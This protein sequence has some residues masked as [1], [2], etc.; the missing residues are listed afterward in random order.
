M[1][2]PRPKSSVSRPGN[3]VSGVSPTETASSL[4]APGNKSKMER[5]AHESEFRMLARIRVIGSVEKV[6]P[7]YKSYVRGRIGDLEVPLFV[8]SGNTFR[9]CINQQMF[10]SL[11]LT[12]GDLQP[13]PERATIG[14]AKR[15]SKLTVK[16]ETKEEIPI[17][18]SPSAPPLMIRLVVLPELEMCVN[19]SGPDLA[20]AGIEIKLSEYLTYRNI[21]V[22]FFKRIDFAEGLK[23]HGAK[24]YT[25]AAV[26]IGPLE[27]VHVNA[28]TADTFVVGKDVYLSSVS[29]F[30]DRYD[31]HPWHN[32]VTTVRAAENGNG[33]TKVGMMNTT[34]IPIKVP[35]GTYYGTVDVL[36]SPDKFDQDPFHLC[37]LE[38]EK[39]DDSRVRTETDPEYRIPPPPSKQNDPMLG[40]DF[41]VPPWMEGPTSLKNWKKRADYLRQLYGVDKNK[42]LKSDT[43][44]VKFLMLLLRNWQTFAWDGRYGNTDLVQH[45]I[46]TPPG[47][48][49]VHI[50]AKY[51]NEFLEQSL[52]EQLKKWLKHGVIQ[53]S[54]S[55]W[56][57]NLLAV[58]KKDNASAVRWC[59]DYRA[60]N[61]ETEIDRFLIGDISDNLSRL[62][63]SRLFSALDNSGAFHI[64]KIAPEDRH[65]TSFATKWN[66]FHFTRLPFGLAG[67]PSSYSR[68]VSQVLR[69]IPPEVAVAYVDD[70]LV[71]S[72]TLDEHI[73]GLSRVLNAYRRAGMKL[74][75]SKCIFLSSKIDYLGHTVSEKGIEP[76]EAYV[77]IVE[78]WPP[79]KTRQDILIAIGKFGYY[80]KFIANFAK[81]AKP[82]TDRLQIVNKEEKKNKEDS[83]ASGQSPRE[84]IQLSKQARKK[85]FEKPITLTPAE[86]KSFND[87]K[88]RLVKYPILGHPRF[89]I[90]EEEPFIL[91]TDW[92]QETGTIAGCLSQKQRQKNGSFREVALGYAA[93]KLGK[94][95]L[96]YSSTK[97]EICA[98]LYFMRYFSYFLTHKKFLIRTDNM[99]ARAIKHADDPPGMIQRWRQRLEAFNFDIVH[100]AGSRH[101]NAD[102]LSR[103]SHVKDNEPAED[104]DVFDE[105]TD[106][107]HLHAI[108]GPDKTDL[109]RQMWT[110]EYIKALQEEDEEIEQVRTW[111]LTKTTPATV[112]R[113]QGS[114]TLK[115]Y[116]NLL[117]SMSIGKDGVLR[118]H[119]VRQAYGDQDEIARWI[120]VLPDHATEQAV[121]AIHKSIAHLRVEN[122]MIAA[123]HY[124][125]NPNL[126]R[127]AEYVCRTC[128]TCQAKG[129]KVKPQSHTLEPP[130]QGYPFFQCNADIVGPL[131]P[132][133]N[134]NV[135]I[136]TVECM[137]TRW[138]E[139]YPLRV[140]T[141][142]SIV[143]KLTKEFFPRFGFPSLLKFDRGTH[144]KNK[145]I[146]ELTEMLGIRI[147]WSPAYHPS[148]NPVERQ[149]RTLKDMLKALIWENT[150]EQPSKWEDFLPAALFALRTMRN[151]ATG[152]SPYELTFG[153]SANTELDLIFGTVPERHE[154]PTY[155]SYH[156]AYMNRMNIAYQ[157]AN[158]NISG[159]IQRCRKYHYNQPKNTFDI[160]SK[161]WLLTP[162]TRPGQRKSFLS[163]W[164]GPWTVSA[165]I[166]EVVYKILPHPSWSRT[167]SSE[168]VTVDR[169]KRYVAPAG[170][171]DDE[172]DID[173]THPPGMNED[174]TFPTDEYLENIP[175][176]ASYD[177][178]DDED[179]LPPLQ[180]APQVQPPIH[181]PQI[182]H[183]Q[184]PP[185]PPQ[186]ALPQAAAAA[187]QRQQPQQLPP[188]HPVQLETQPPVP[189]PIVPEPPQHESTPQPR[190]RR[191]RKTPPPPRELPTRR[192][193]EKSQYGRPDTRK[194]PQSDDDDD[195]MAM[196]IDDDLDKTVTAKQHDPLEEIITADPSVLLNPDT[197]VED[198][199]PDVDLSDQTKV[200]Q[201]R[202]RFA[203]Q[204]AEARGRAEALDDRVDSHRR[205]LT[206]ARQLSDSNLQKLLQ[207]PPAH[208]PSVGQL[209]TLGASA[210]DAPLHNRV[211]VLRD[212]AGG[213]Q[214]AA[215]SRIQLRCD[216]I[217]LRTD[218]IDE[219]VSTDRDSFHSAHDSL[220][221]DS[222]TTPPKSPKKTRSRSLSQ[223]RP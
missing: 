92:C 164:S 175:T 116:I 43:E 26:T 64:I 188:E 143:N 210:A 108:G 17:Y 21:R 91:D 106:R 194:K 177:S 86:L 13:L 59:V 126:R 54:D 53:P 12:E 31:L 159:A 14:T 65:K 187:P 36:T 197:T 93:K 199:F 63:G 100:R 2:N 75:P 6:R 81:I 145:L 203:E 105:E 27:R 49:P 8:D 204:H 69:G 200:L 154:Y 103:C 171:G 28:V 165:K 130:R 40:D 118:Y 16:G 76:Q 190:R 151:A 147:I 149:H 20:A 4:N 222:F 77:K 148:G 125:Y 166:N 10:N 219:T 73:S 104:V 155:V 114:A 144:F 101:G 44:R 223:S 150:N 193:V 79:P 48:R 158:K 78:N 70:V 25:A 183:H 56:N 82:L 41:Y 74:N 163:P 201:N 94:S 156:R 88:A 178:D 135:Y 45:Y 208:V 62:G 141:G 169:I 42:N 174:L 136:L 215:L 181:A 122:T 137:F 89:N 218:T 98:I 128:L 1:S 19:L 213:Q 146:E 60:L 196:A 133:S 33:Y 107:Q 35:K 167:R 37:L 32:V 46:K 85:E 115:A 173:N 206:H 11:G 172:D 191:R 186:A 55:C 120:I 67:G 134:N 220:T 68:L 87:L 71:H 214:A 205:R 117:K 18:I 50:R 124:V 95:Q 179:P 39:F 202:R 9:S 132:S 84:A 138:L 7:T 170:E 189:E 198:E 168:T 61:A 29:D 152:Y 216:E 142:Q 119:Y 109:P 30:S 217:Q 127:I 97:G 162:V 153:R 209:R 112:E 47:G 38:K 195:Q 80:R 161:V 123:L 5:N 182:P 160:G 34:G 221:T 180:V 176:K 140:A 99:A 207:S 58:A 113:A 90:N 3:P 111:V 72:P 129:G 52:K 185:R 131:V 192:A 83:V 15:D 212:E 23:R 96:H 184:E 139:A 22:P 102:A 211:Q 66:S 110:S 57:S 24:L 157:W 51:Q 121:T